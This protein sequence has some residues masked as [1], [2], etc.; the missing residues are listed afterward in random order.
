MAIT[1]KQVSDLREKTQCGMMDCKKALEAS[2]GDIEKAV[3]WLRKKGM[4][5]AEEKAGRAAN[6]G[7]VAIKADGNAVAMVELLCETDFVARNPQFKAYGAKLADAV[8]AYD[9][10]GDV[11]AKLAAQFSDDLKEFIGVIKENMKIR[12]AIRW[13]STEGKIGFYVHTATPYAAMVELAGE[14]NDELPQ[15]VAMQVVSA[16]P[17]FICPKCIPEDRIAKEREIALA[18]APQGK[19][20]NIIDGIVNGK[21]NKWYS[22]V[23]LVKQPWIF[24]DKTTLEK[25]APKARVL[26]FVRWTAGE[27]LEG[28]QA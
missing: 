22:Q 17:K 11:S 25:A 3:E 12:R 23:C 15:Q 14:F 19:P 6:Q 21:L 2:D 28:E 27:S 18:T 10:E 20:Q 13:V 5:R 24:D 9:G 26:R 8:L 16:D 7:I 4:A 1:A